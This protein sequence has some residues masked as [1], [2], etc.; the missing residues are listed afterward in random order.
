MDTHGI[1]EGIKILDLTQGIAGPYC[2]KLL[3][4][5]GAEVIKVEKPDRGDFMRRIGPFAGNIP[6]PGAD[7]LPFL[8]LNTNKKSITLELS[9]VT[10]QEILKALVAS[11]DILLESFMPGTMNSWKMD[12]GTLAKTNPGLVM[13]SITNFGQDGPYKNYEATELI[14]YAL[15]GLL[16]ITGDPEREPIKVGTEMAQ[17]VAGQYAF[18]ATMGAFYHKQMTGEGQYIDHSIME[19]NAGAMEFQLSQ[20]QFQNYI[21]KRIG[22]ANEK[23]HPQGM[24]PCKDGWV[25]L[26]IHT[27]AGWPGVVRVTGVKELDKPEFA[28]DEGRIQ[29]RDEVDAYLIP[30]LLDHTEED[31]VQSWDDAGLI[32]S[33][34]HDVNELMDVAQLKERQYFLEIDHPQTG[35]LKYPR[36]PFAFTTQKWAAIRAPLLG[37]HN[38]EILGQRLGYSAE[39]LRRLKEGKVI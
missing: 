32:A 20:Y 30:W 9:C 11:A 17:Y 2:T 14:L 34:V 5:L 15:S 13:T 31:V 12:Y 35:K 39:D 27:K 36:G 18:T 29:N 1:L 21:P 38:D 26:C 22:Y 24:F 37:E 19:C 25:A 10:G 4:G 16:Y 6:K 7:G 3:A 33:K 23:G 28:T 8:Y